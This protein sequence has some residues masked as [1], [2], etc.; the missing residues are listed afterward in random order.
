[1]GPGS[2]MQQVNI[3]TETFLLAVSALSTV[4]LGEATRA[5]PTLPA[6]ST[7]LIRG[8]CSTEILIKVG[9]CQHQFLSPYAYGN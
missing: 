3:S 8:G 5:L 9:V 7:W 4:G 6:L 2:I 1:M